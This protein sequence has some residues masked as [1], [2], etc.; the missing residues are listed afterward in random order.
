MKTFQRS[1]VWH[2]RD[3]RVQ[4]NTALNEALK[5]SEKIVPLFIFDDGI[6]IGRSDFS[7]A[8]VKFMIESLDALQKEYQTQGGKLIL[9]RGKPL[10]VLKA[11]QKETNA[12]AVFFNEDYESYAKQRDGKIIDYFTSIGI[13][14]QSCFD[15]LCIHPD[16]IKTT[17]NQPYTVFT[18]FKKNWLNR[19]N[20]I[21][22]P[23]ELPK[24]IKAGSWTSVALPNSNDLCSG[25]DV[26]ILVKGGSDNGKRQWQAFL[27][28]KIS[29]YKQHRDFPGLDGTSLLSAHLRFG[30]L[31][32]RQLFKD[33]FLELEKADQNSKPGIDTFMSELIWREFYFG[34]LYHFP[35]VERGCFK[36]ELDTIK[37]ENR[38]DY[39]E[40]WKA[41]QTGFPIVDAAMRQLVQTGW[42]HN[43]LR[44]IVASFL[45][46][47][48]LIDWRWGELFFMQHL[49]DGDLGLNNGGW[50]WAASTGTDA[51]PYFRIFNPTLQSQKFDPEGQFIRKYVPELKNLPAKYIH[52]PYEFYKKS[53]FVLQEHGVYLG[54][55]YPFPIV[56]HKTQREKALR[57]YKL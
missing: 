14:I 34:V 20:Q 23:Q 17:Q 37:W 55:N 13:F 4:D 40:A 15:T 39:F 8:C 9:R 25:K 29:S 51:Q 54:E 6:L 47:D 35:Y 42:M 10:E 27:T 56:D 49:I 33:A 7:P 1:I 12:E 18:P 50:Q 31:S 21:L 24:P 52:N 2:R 48:L 26:E 45:T 57:M 44:M 5:C 38:E 36:Q 41:G 22:K 43:R 53:P 28:T 19:T 46:K 30:T 16:Q 32:I 3:L 11:L